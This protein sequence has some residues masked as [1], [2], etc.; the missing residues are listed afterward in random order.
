MDHI[1]LTYDL[2]I[3]SKSVMQI[4]VFD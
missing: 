2:F 3:F 4:S 1:L